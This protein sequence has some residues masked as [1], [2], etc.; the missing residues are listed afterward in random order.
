MKSLC[1]AICLLLLTALSAR[2][3]YDGW[4]HAGSIHVLTTPHGAD[5]PAS[6]T[7]EG[8]PILVRLHKDFFDFTQAKPN[9]D[10]LRF[11]T[12]AGE[13]LAHQIDHWDAEKGTASVWV[14]VPK[15]Q[16]NARQEIKLHWGKPDVPSE[17]NGAA[18]FNASNGYLSVW[19]M[20]PAAKDEVGTL[21]T[22]DVGT[23]A[24]AGMIGEAR[25]LAG[26]QGYFG[27]DKIAGYP[28]GVDS[29]STQAW[30][31]P[32]V[33]ST[34]IV[35]WG[36]EEGGRG[37]KV[38][39][40][41]RS[42]P[43]IRIDS[44]FSDVKGES[45]LPLSQWTHVVHTYSK[46]QGRVYI[47][48]KLDGSATPTLTIKS[49]ARLWIG[50]WYNNYDFVGDVD[51][52]RISNVTRSADWV[53]AEYEN[54]KPM[55]T[56]VGPIVQPG[57]AFDVSPAAITVD[58]GKTAIVTAKAGGAEKVYW[59]LKRDGVETPLAVDRFSL[60]FDAGRVTQD[61]TLALIFKAVYAGE[62]KTR[63]IPVTIKE[64]IP[65]PEFTLEAPATWD[66]RTQIEVAARVS[67]RDAM[68]AAGTGLS[69]RWKTADIAVTSTD[70]PYALRLLRAQN[71]G[72]LT[73]TAECSNGGQPV[74]R[75]VDIAVTE[76]ARGEWL[77][78]T[79]AKDE[80]PVDN[81]FYARDDKNEGTLH[82]NGVL[83]AKADSVFLRVTADG[84]PYQDLS[85]KPGPD[86]GYAFAVKLKPGLIKYAVQ[87]G[88]KTGDKETILHTATNL[89]CGDAYIINGQSNAQAVAWGKGDFDFT[90]TWIRTFASAESGAQGARLHQW[91]DAIARGQGGKLQVGYWGLDLARRLVESQKMPICIINGAVGGTRIDQHQRNAADAEDVTTIYGRLLWRVRAAGLSNGI[92]GVLWHQ[93]ENDQGA[94]GPTGGFGYETYRAY[95]LDL[96]AAWKQDFPNIQHY[97]VFQIWPKACAMGVNGSDN[98]LREVQRTLPTAFSRMS[99][100]STLGIQPPGGCHYE[101]A[102]YAEIARLIQPLIER[103]HYGKKFDGPITP[104][105]LRRAFF[106]N[107]ERTRIVLEFDQPIVWDDKLAGQFYLD[108]ASGQVTSGKVEGNRLTLNLAGPSSA[109]RIT[110]LDSK[111]WSQDKLLRGTNGIAALTF[112]DVP[113]LGSDAPR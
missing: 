29:H 63:E 33:S 14:R 42:P 113:V 92:R 39:M 36:N 108:G 56:L 19:H 35:A 5:L 109:A 48:G 11:S 30:F 91:G 54:Q 3:G 106:A 82:C 64:A 96:A 12:P 57:Q 99:V 28:T 58:E 46:G 85:Q 81:Q 78:R 34:T 76:P 71:S 40:Q 111:A 97:Y 20:G 7:L 89:V 17:S 75:S 31:R 88:T 53:R 79:P 61:Q 47:N 1:I 52:V 43:H 98:H 32:E 87:L 51:E 59:T 6:A 26:K 16:G 66:G 104:A 67:N 74:T 8:F 70:V 105:D 10:D 107:A 69:V 37:S 45:T 18:V 95:F 103:D 93:G 100:M 86:L 41:L 13:S 80:K 90:S 112:C 68:T 62:V 72:K 49:P 4:A 77:Q 38:R 9:G 50:G 110:Y 23:T 55:Q 60:P 102:G 44:N 2:A 73:V 15:I 24:A 27:G 101:P 25:H 22:K 65:D 21:Q 84:Q 94:D 83:S